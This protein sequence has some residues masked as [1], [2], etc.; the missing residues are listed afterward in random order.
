MR[1]TTCA[2]SAFAST[3]KD[4]SSVS[5]PVNIISIKIASISGFVSTKRVLFVVRI[6]SQ[7]IE[8]E[9]IVLLAVKEVKIKKLIFISI[10]KMKME[11]KMEAKDI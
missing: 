3:K 1:T 6:S 7:A 4:R 8:T 10:V 2:R 9:K 11:M 5:C